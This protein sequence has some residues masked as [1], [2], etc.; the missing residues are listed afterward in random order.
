MKSTTTVQK[1]IYYEWFGSINKYEDL[2]Y[3]G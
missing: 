1:L 3:K 2:D